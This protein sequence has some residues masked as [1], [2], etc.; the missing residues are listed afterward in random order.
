M[1][2]QFFHTDEMSSLN[3]QKGFLSGKMC[4][5]GPA[6]APTHLLLLLLLLVLSLPLFLVGLLEILD[7]LLEPLPVRLAA[8]AQLLQRAALQL[9]Q[10]FANHLPQRRH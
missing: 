6:G 9:Q 7:A 5:A 2:I 1:E 10:L 3:L 8:H 4:E